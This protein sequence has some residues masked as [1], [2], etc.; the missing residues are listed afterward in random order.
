M[1]AQ[2]V[3]EFCMGWTILI[4]CSPVPEPRPPCRCHLRVNYPRCIEVSQLSD[5]SPT[6]RSGLQI[7]GITR[8]LQ[9]F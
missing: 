5:C 2:P 8:A 1:I 4:A 7:R 6:V 9:G 3:P